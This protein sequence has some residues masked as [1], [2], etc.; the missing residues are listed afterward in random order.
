MKMNLAAD[1]EGF[2]YFHEILFAVFKV[3]MLRREG[4]VDKSE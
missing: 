3:E 4:D 1:S 2:L